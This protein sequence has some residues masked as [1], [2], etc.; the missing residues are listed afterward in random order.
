MLTSLILAILFGWLYISYK[1]LDL[2]ESY[3]IYL[4]LLIKK[5]ESK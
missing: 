1:R 2:L 4:K 3:I 5:R